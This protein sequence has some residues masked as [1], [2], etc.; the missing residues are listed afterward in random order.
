MSRPRPRYFPLSPKAAIQWVQ[1]RTGAAA[2][3]VRK[4]VVDAVP[5]FMK[6]MVDETLGTLM[7]YAKQQA[8][9]QI[10]ALRRFAGVVPGTGN[11]AQVAQAVLDKVMAMAPRVRL[12]RGRQAARTLLR[13]WRAKPRTWRPMR[14]RVT[15]RIRRTRKFAM[16]GYGKGVY[17]KLPQYRGRVVSNSGAMSSEF[18]KPPFVSRM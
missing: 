16:R 15:Q 8:G 12:A 10:D 7:D 1:K 14:S 6:P 2:S 13:R 3:T 4:R 18:A 17:G 9:T 5:D 11:A